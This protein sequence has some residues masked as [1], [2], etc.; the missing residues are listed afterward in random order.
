MNIGAIVAV[1]ALY[2]LCGCVCLVCLVS[3]HDH[4][5][6]KTRAMAYL[7]PLTLC[8]LVFR[9]IFSIVKTVSE[10]VINVTNAWLDNN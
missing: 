1:V 2:T 4:I 7:W 5:G 10:E 3:P 9:L 8:M 6:S